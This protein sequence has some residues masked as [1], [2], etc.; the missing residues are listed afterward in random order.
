MRTESFL[1][2][3]YKYIYALN[4]TQS[5]VIVTCLKHFKQWLVWINSILNTY[6]KTFFQHFTL[7]F[8]LH[9]GSRLKKIM[10]V[11]L[12]IVHPICMSR[13][14]VKYTHQMCRLYLVCNSFWSSETISESD[15]GLD[16]DTTWLTHPNAKTS[17]YLCI[18]WGGQECITSKE[19]SMW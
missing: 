4:T 14:L 19:M 18:A 9:L 17:G 12:K 3:I 16:K 1:T 13:A 2:D 11:L 7:S 6:P 15:S 5:Y 8:V 10:P